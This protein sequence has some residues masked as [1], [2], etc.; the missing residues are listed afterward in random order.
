M[1]KNQEKIHRS[2]KPYIAVYFCIIGH[3]LFYRLSEMREKNFLSKDK[4]SYELEDWSESSSQSVSD[5]VNRV[6]SLHHYNNS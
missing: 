2:F 5:G 4:V 1:L 6:F 3:N